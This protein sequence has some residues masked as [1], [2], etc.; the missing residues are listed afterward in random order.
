MGTVTHQR[1]N[2]GTLKSTKCFCFTEHA[3]ILL[4]GEIAGCDN[5]LNPFDNKTIFFVLRFSVHKYALIFL[6]PTFVIVTLVFFF[7][8]KSVA[9]RTPQI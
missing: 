7:I 4:S 2:P 6:I 9:G 3:M 8:V 5:E 1:R